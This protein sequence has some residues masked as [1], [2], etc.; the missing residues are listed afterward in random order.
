MC[1][2]FSLLLFFA[3][4]QTCWA[5]ETTPY[6]IYSYSTADKSAITIEEVTFFQCMYAFY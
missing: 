4:T 2:L 1:Q 6:I 5:V 3:V